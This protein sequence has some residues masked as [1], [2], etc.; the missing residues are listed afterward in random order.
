MRQRRAIFALK[1]ENPE[2]NSGIKLKK[3]TYSTVEGCI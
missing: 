3:T 1:I 2:I